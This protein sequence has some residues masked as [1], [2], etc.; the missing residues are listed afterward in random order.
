MRHRLNAS[1]LS[2]FAAIPYFTINGF[3]QIA[4]I[5][6]VDD[7]RARVAL[8]RWS[9]AGHV[10]RLKKGVYMTRQ[11]YE[12][13]RGDPSFSSAV[14]AM[15]KP[16]SYVSLE[17]IL[18]RH[19]I[20]TEA[21]YPI[22]A[23]TTKHTRVFENILGTLTYKHIRPDLYHGFSISDYYGVSFAEASLAKALFD[24]LY[25]RPL[26]I[27][28]RVSGFNLAEELR[29]NLGEFSPQDREQFAKYVQESGVTKMVDILEKLGK[30]TW[31][32]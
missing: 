26:A 31:R 3:R 8:Y 14:S 20:L 23:V 2:S 24:F 16:Q 21:A 11:F 22:T 28:T 4:G 5:D 12:G 6:D 30:T 32:P 15:I 25:L 17:T 27:V 10:I 29:L 1:A 18:Q 19:G 13:H 9:K 7:E